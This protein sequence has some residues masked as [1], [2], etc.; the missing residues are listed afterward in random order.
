MC[1]AP[2]ISVN[3]SPPAPFVT[4]A[5]LPS[6]SHSRIDCSAKSSRPVHSSSSI[7]ALFPTWL[8]MKSFL[9]TYT[10]T[11][12]PRSRRAATWYCAGLH[13]SMLLRKAWMTSQSADEKFPVREGSTPSFRR[14]SGRSRYFDT[15]GNDVRQLYISVLE[16]ISD[17]VISE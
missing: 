11:R 4:P 14:T 2:S 8:Q 1:P 12:T 7:H 15:L 3:V 5:G 17:L 13:S 9:P 10:S 6:T 16:V